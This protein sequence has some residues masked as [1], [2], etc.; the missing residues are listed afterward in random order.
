[1]RGFTSALRIFLDVRKGSPTQNACGVQAR[2][3]DPSKQIGPSGGSDILLELP[4]SMLLEL[5]SCPIR[6]SKVLQ[7]EDQL[8]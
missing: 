4:E 1:M 6:R 5:D 3:S 7:K 8:G 2:S